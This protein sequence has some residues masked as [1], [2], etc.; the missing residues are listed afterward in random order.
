MN[1]LSTMDEQKNGVRM[2]ERMNGMDA[3]NENE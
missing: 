2:N 3:R 1:V